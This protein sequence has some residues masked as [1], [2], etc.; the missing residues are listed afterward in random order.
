M[1][2]L[3]YTSWSKINLKNTNKAEFIKDVYSKDLFLYPN[4]YQF[5]LFKGFSLINPLKNT[6]SPIT[7]PKKSDDHLY[8]PNI[9]SNPPGHFRGVL[10]I[11]FYYKKR[12]CGVRTFI[13]ASIDK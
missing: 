9:G 6:K 3:K 12:H 11:D 1:R 13:N 7:T 8:H 2:A 4:K 10:H 5:Y